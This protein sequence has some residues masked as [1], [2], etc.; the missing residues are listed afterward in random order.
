MDPYKTERTASSCGGN[1][2]MSSEKKKKI[3]GFKKKKAQ[4]GL[5]KLWETS[6]KKHFLLAF[7]FY[8]HITIMSTNG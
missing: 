3:K 7:F 4:I 2:N 6:G 5:F 8:I 1:S